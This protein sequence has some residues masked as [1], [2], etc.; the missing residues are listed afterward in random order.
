MS[1]HNEGVTQKTQ[2]YSQMELYHS[3]SSN[4]PPS[5]GRVHLINI[6]NLMFLEGDFQKN[7]KVW[8]Y[9][10]NTLGMQIQGRNNSI[11]KGMKAS[12]LGWGIPSNENQKD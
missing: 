1:V 9:S 6:S 8:I 7:P 11:H 5:L 3:S 2:S 10:A 4:C 12:D